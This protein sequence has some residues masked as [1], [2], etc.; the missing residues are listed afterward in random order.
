MVRYRR[1]GT[2]ALF[3]AVVVAGPLGCERKSDTEEA[4]EE[5]QD[6]IEDAADKTKNKIE[7][8]KD[9]IEDEIDDAN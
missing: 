4:V 5:I 6:E 3:L 7:D 2:A 8:A 1:L 9:E